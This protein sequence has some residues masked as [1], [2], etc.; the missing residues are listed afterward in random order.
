MHKSVLIQARWH[1]THPSSAA[2]V[3]NART[4]AVLVH[5]AGTGVSSESQSIS[6]HWGV[7]AVDKS[8]EVKRIQVVNNTH[9]LG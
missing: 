8:H 4:S 9:S 1:H 5:N 6:V 7:C 3:C 2:L